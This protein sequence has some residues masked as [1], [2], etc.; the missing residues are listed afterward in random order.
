MAEWENVGRDTKAGRGVVANEVGAV[1][2][3][4]VTKLYEEVR[5]ERAS[6]ACP[7]PVE[8]RSVAMVDGDEDEDSSFRLSLSVPTSTHDLFVPLR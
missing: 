5:A 4:L 2:V 1:F 6:A 8:G 3:P 7:P